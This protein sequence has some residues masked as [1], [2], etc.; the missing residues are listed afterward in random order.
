MRTNSEEGKKIIESFFIGLGTFL[1]TF[2]LTDELRNSLLEG[3]KFLFKKI[4]EE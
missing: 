1:A 2:R 4:Y 3:G